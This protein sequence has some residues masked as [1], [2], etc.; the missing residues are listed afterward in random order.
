MRLGTRHG[1]TRTCHREGIFAVSL[2][3]S[4]AAPMSGPCRWQRGA[5][6]TPAMRMARWRITDN[7]N[8]WIKA[9]DENDVKKTREAVLTTLE[10]AE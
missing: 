1:Q 10:P 3:R 9:G 4:E 8:L 5:C 7:I 2:P 6:Y